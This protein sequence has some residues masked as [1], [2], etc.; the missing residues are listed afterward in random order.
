M[1]TRWRSSIIS[2]FKSMRSLA[3]YLARLEAECQ[4]QRQRAAAPC[5]LG[6]GQAAKR[7][8]DLTALRIV[9]DWGGGLKMFPRPAPG[10]RSLQCGLAL[11]ARR[12]DTWQ[13][14]PEQ[15]QCRRLRDL[16]AF[17]FESGNKA[18]LI[19]E[20][21]LA[22][23]TT[24][25]AAKAGS[26]RVDC[27]KRRSDIAAI[28]FNVHQQAAHTII[29][30][31]VGNIDNEIEARIR[32]PRLSRK[33]LHAAHH[34]D[35]NAEVGC[36]VFAQNNRVKISDK[37]AMILGAT[38]TACESFPVNAQ[39]AR[40]NSC[41]TGNMY[42]MSV[43][44]AWLGALGSLLE[45]VFGNWQAMV[46]VRR[47]D[48]L[49][50][51]PAAQAHFTPQACDPVSARDEAMLPQFGLYTLRAVG[52]AALPVLG[53]DSHLQHRILPGSRGRPHAQRGIKSATRN[54]KRAAQSF[55]RIVGSHCLHLRVPGSDSHAK[56]AVAF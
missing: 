39:A 33:R 22:I 13:C 55:D 49:A 10:H 15:G 36:K 37:K 35:A 42:V 43:P 50:Q 7:R 45:Q 52:V 4:C 8:Q 46:R 29:V 32:A 19:A 5:Q 53:L 14:N 9:K 30:K 25:Y 6:S 40:R 12:R 28:E 16:G 47:G 48:D 54:L 21:V 56:Y 27:I 20:T 24:K 34:N 3:N 31:R 26:S 44:H 41:T 2:L 11:A 23:D 38:W 18:R 17:Y 51:L 1:M